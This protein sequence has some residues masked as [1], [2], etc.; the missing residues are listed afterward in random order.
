MFVSYTSV[1]SVAP[2]RLQ[3]FHIEWFD[4]TFGWFDFSTPFSRTSQKTARYSL[5]FHSFHVRYS[6]SSTK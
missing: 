5:N 1:N 2:K 4:T 6:V 3:P